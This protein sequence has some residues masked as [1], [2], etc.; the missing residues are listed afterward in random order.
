MSI[1]AKVS[2]RHD[3]LTLLEQSRPQIG[4]LVSDPKRL[5]RTIR[6][7]R[8]AW[9]MDPEIQKCTP[10]SILG[11]VMRAC[12]LNLD[13]HGGRKHAYLVRYANSCQLLVSYTGLL[14]LARR[15]GEFSTIETRIVY[16]NEM[17]SLTYTPEAQIVHQPELDGDPG[18]MT[19]VYAYARFKHGGLA[20]EIMTAKEVEAIR[21]RAPSKNSPAWRD[22]YGEMSRKVVLKRLL[23]RLPQS[24]E[25]AAVI[26]HDNTIEAQAQVAR[27]N[28]PAAA[29]LTERLEA[30]HAKR[31][32]DS[33]KEVE[34]ESQIPP[35]VH[36]DAYEPPTEEPARPRKP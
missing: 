3:F 18:Q 22:Y 4:L 15:S 27:V 25:L 33:P 8:T 21:L 30:A 11:S 19:H 32:I 1:P 35:D 6:M 5:D 16:R 24:E 2:P 28:V 36:G 23:K 17:L 20:F 12:E 34:S 13:I 26:E 14:E 10:D 31:A 29:S 7:I 9:M